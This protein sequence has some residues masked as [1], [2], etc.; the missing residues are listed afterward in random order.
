[1]RTGAA[2]AVLWLT[3]SVVIRAHEG[4]PFPIVQDQIAGGYRV[5]LW[6]DPDT[7][8][9]RSPG[10]QFWVR[11]APARPA[12][13][14]PSGTRATV[15]VS[16]L[17]RQG[18]QEQQAAAPVKGDVTNQFASLVMDH[19]GRFAVHVAITGPLGDAT[20]DAQVA[21]TY[22]LRPPPLLLLVYVAPFVAI[23]ILW[24][25][26]VSKRRT[27]QRGDGPSRMTGSE[28]RV[29]RPTR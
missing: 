7:T 11:L 2:V 21:A 1:M 18:P 17:D 4:P 9:D 24:L 13:T 23:G 29:T 3:A 22:N 16:P 14:L 12:G 5:S 25:R 10:G 26:I 28:P 6:T 20:V 27:V 8:D 15:S 19:E